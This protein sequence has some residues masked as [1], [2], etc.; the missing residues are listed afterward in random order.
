MLLKKPVP[1]L[2]LHH[3]Y[4]FKTQL[5]IPHILRTILVRSIIG[6]DRLYGTGPGISSPKLYCFDG[7][8]PPFQTINLQINL[9]RKKW[10]LKFKVL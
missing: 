2:S 9:R 10:F 5:Y 6:Y 8:Y 1:Y 4:K 3:H 7:K